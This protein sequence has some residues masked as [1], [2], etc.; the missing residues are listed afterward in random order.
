[1]LMPSSKIMFWK[2]ALNKNVHTYI[3]INA[4]IFICEKLFSKTQSMNLALTLQA[5]SY[6]ALEKSSTCTVSYTPGMV[7]ELVE[8]GPR[9]Q[10]IGS[11]V[12]GRVKPMSYKIDICH[13][14]GT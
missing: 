13:S 10:K 3:M 4:H 7:A 6:R 1:M 14:L 5:H 8:H 12:P 2:R 9:V 11:S